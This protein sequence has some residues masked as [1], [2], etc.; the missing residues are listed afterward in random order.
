MGAKFLLESGVMG[1]R[2]VEMS[3]M[4][5]IAE[6]TGG[7]VILTLAD[8]EGS[9]SFDVSM[10]GEAES[11]AQERVASNELLIIRGGS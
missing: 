3:D 4:K 1:V 2:R 10:L 8:L 7:Q 6:A 11:V 9:E 5:H